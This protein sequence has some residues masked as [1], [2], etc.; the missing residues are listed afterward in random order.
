MDTISVKSNIQKARKDLRLTQAQ[1]AGR[2]GISR[3]AYRNLEKG[4]TK[5]F[6]DHISRLAELSGKSEE[7]LVLGYSPK[8]VQQSALHDSDSRIEHFDSLR[9]EYERRLS[10]KDKIIEAQE[11]SIKVL[12]DMLSII[13]R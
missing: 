11:T 6:S 12:K 9:Q 8:S 2:L 13:N 4:D 10:E 7:E 3:T 5:V 1:M